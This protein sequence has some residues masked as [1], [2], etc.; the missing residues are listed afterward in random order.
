MR[1][2]SGTLPVDAGTYHIAIID[3]GEGSRTDRIAGLAGEH[4]SGREARPGGGGEHVAARLQR[5]DLAVGQDVQMQERHGVSPS[6]ARRR[7]SGRGGVGPV[8]VGEKK[9]RYALRMQR[10]GEWLW[11]ASR[12][13]MTA[14][15]ATCPAEE[16]PKRSPGTIAKA[17]PYAG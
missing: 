5:G 16:L 8:V 9:P 2:G 3:R 13:L 17:S 1:A 10:I 6:G 14:V 7:P 15:R 4:D 12:L 11:R